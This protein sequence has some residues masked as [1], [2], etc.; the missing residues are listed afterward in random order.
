MK[1]YKHIFYGAVAAATLAACSNDIDPAGGER[2]PDG[3]YPL[4]ITASMQEMS[5]RAGGEKTTWEENDVIG[6]RI[7]DESV[8]GK[9]I[10][11]DTEGTIVEAETPLYWN[12]PD[13][14]VVTAWYPYEPTTVNIADQSSEDFTP[15]DFLLASESASIRNSVNLRFTH[16]MARMWYGLENE[17]G[18]SES[19][20]QNVKVKFYGYTS[21]ASDADGKLTGS[22]EGWIT[23]G[24][25]GTWYLPQNMTG[26]ELIRVTATIDGQSKT[27]VYSPDNTNGGDIVPG[28]Q[29]SYTITVKRDRIEVR[30]VAGA[31]WTDGGSQDVNSDFIPVGDKPMADVQAGDFYFSDGTFADKDTELTKRQANYCVGIV[32]YK[33]QHDA[34]GSD[35]SGSGIG[36]QKCNGY[37]VALTDVHN[38][39]NDQLCWETAPNGPN[40]NLGTNASGLDLSDW[41]G[42]DNC[43]KI[44][45]FVEDN[46]ED[47]WEMK[48]FPAAFACETY[49]SRTLDQDGNATTAYEWQRQFIAPENTSGWFLPSL[50]QLKYLYDNQDDLKLK[51]EKV[52]EKAPNMVADYIRWFKMDQYLSST[53]TMTSP[54][55]YFF[56]F[57]DGM[58]NLVNFL[59]SR[60]VRAILAF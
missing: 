6:V 17:A 19:D 12:S 16:R 42:Y 41:E 43:L 47:G 39:S 22:A 55:D 34:D 49:G 8:T 46:S 25:D 57:Q 23:P 36:Q 2:L 26:K 50:G 30:A 4:E 11:R 60:D 38:G 15:V 1:K 27:F 56:D 3:K 20:W 59:S 31:E 21:V 28:M 35:Y 54:A 10:I 58:H 33:G 48:N 51:I 24:T 13:Y 45:K 9:Y 18:M 37:V 14:T 44:H 7:G 40:K 52:K 29:Y 5:T 53:E 32:F